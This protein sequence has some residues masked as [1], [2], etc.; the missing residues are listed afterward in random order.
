M[1]NKQVNLVW[2]KR[3]LRLQD[4]KPLAEA[5]KSDLPVL[6]LYIHETNIWSDPHYSKRHEQFVRDSIEELEAKLK[7]RGISMLCCRATFGKTFDFLQSHFDI[8]TVFSFQETG[9]RCTYERDKQAALYFQ[10]CHISW[11]EYQQNG[12]IRALSHRKSWVPQWYKFMS[13]PWDEPEWQSYTHP[14]VKIPKLPFPSFP[15]NTFLMNSHFQKGGEQRAHQTLQSF[16]ERRGAKYM[17]SISKPQAAREHCSRLSP[18]LA[19]GNLSIRQVWQALQKSKFRKAQPFHAKAFGSRL[20]WHCHF[21]QKFEM[22]DRMEFENV[23]RGYNELDRSFDDVK[24]RRWCRGQT[25]FPLVDACM[26]AVY[27]TGYLNFRM[28][29]MVLSFWTHHLWQDWKPAAI[30]LARQFLD[31]EPGIHYPQIQMQAGVTGINTIRIYN[32]IKQSEDH[33]PEGAFIQK[34]CPELQSVPSETIHKPAEMTGLEQGM[35]RCRIGEDYPEPMVD[36]K[37]AGNNARDSL[38]SIKKKKKVKKEGRRIL[39]KLTNPGRRQA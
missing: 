24:W 5:L 9:L 12:V 8:K 15:S 39:R 7:N 3:D 21:I 18:H 13:S 4:H 38:W 29:A 33:D 31:F 32:P 30:W 34:W 17:N 23:N 6:G 16:L 36:L 27:H 26:R 2:F 14:L 11:K 10:R 1:R 35:Y 22:E 25:G 28:R 20:R 19:W 37:A